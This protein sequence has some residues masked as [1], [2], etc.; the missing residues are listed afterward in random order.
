MQRPVNYYR[1]SVGAVPGKSGFCFSTATGSIVCVFSTAGTVSL[2]YLCRRFWKRAVDSTPRLARPCLPDPRLSR[3]WSKWEG[4]RAFAGRPSRAFRRAASGSSTPPVL[5][6]PLLLPAGTIPEI[7]P[8]SD[9]RLSS[10][11]PYR[12]WVPRQRAR[13]F[14]G[15]LKDPRVR[16]KLNCAA[17]RRAGAPLC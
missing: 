7:C 10:T 2:W 6:P 14:E 9:D 5:G 3:A 15:L 12:F 17:F 8:I 13:L 11:G 1:T 16:L 4:R